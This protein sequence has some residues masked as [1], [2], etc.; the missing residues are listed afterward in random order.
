MFPEIPDAGFGF[1]CATIYFAKSDIE[2]GK[3]NN[4]LLFY[5]KGLSQNFQSCYFC[6]RSTHFLDQWWH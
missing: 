5:G 2:F 1:E 6:F 3:I 4:P